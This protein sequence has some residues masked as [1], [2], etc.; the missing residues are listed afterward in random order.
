MINLSAEQVQ[1]A[2]LINAHVN[3]Y[4]DTALGDEQLLQ[5]AYD[6]MGAFK[7][8]M[9]SSTS[10][11]MDYLSQQYTGFYRFGKLLE[12]LAQGIADGEI[13]VPNDQ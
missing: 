2:T 6:Y 10:A 11:Q 7:R 8:I 4:P 5:T 3:R 13:D 9:D 12:S 1:L